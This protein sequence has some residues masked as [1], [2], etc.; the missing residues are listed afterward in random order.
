MKLVGKRQYFLIFIVALSFSECK[1]FVQV[2]PPVTSITGA[3]VY[4]NST[5]AAATVTSIYDN[6]VANTA[7]S[8]GGASIGLLEGCAADELTNYSST[9][10]IIPPFYLNHLNSTNSDPGWW[11]ELYKEIYVAN[12]VI[13]GLASSSGVSQASKA[14]LTGEAKFMRAFLLFYAVNL[15]GDVPLVT[16]TNY[17]QNNVAKRTPARQVYQQII[18]D[19]TDAQS[20][21]SNNFVDPYGKVITARVR[22]NKGAATALLARTYLYI[23]QWD[24]AEIQ[25]STI[26]NSTGTY[27]LSSLNSVFLA[28]STEAIWQFQPVYPGLN[29]WDARFYVLTSAPGTGSTNVAISSNLMNSF[30]AGDLRATKWVGTFTRDSTTYYYFPY[31]YKIWTVNPNVPATEYT[32]VLRLGEQYL[33]RAEARAQQGNIQGAQADLNVIR[34]RAGLPN[35][36]ANDKASLLAAILHER[37][38]ELFS[39]WGH[40]WFDLIRTGNINSVMGGPGN[41][42]RTKGGSWAP[43]WALMPIPASEIRINPNLTQNAG[44]TN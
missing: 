16:S 21:L 27:S 44:Y 3:T 23:N 29:N 7:L 1:K 12:A 15:Y 43:E 18:R 2:D 22:P 33:I 9:N 30:E 26:V 19:L 31:K 36:S 24:S 17:Q 39:E 25:A 13:E 40:R 32:T 8:S 41:V 20:L 28:N 38:V 6:M 42:C 37:Q 35:T 14:Q 10:T 34:T 4:N 5:S 11:S